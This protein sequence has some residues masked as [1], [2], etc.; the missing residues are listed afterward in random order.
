MCHNRSELG[1]NRVSGGN[2]LGAKFKDSYG[3]DMRLEKFAIG[4]CVLEMMTDI[5]LRNLLFGL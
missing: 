5:H 2:D 1:R 3:F 4:C